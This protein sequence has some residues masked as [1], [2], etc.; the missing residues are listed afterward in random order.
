MNDWSAQQYL[1]FADERTRPAQDLLARV[2]LDG[3]RL[4][5]DIGCGPGNS[6]ELLA[7]RWPEAKV[8]G[9]DSSP[10]ML[11]DARKRL[12]NASFE[13]AD[14]ANWQPPEAPDLLFANAILQWLPD[15][16]LVIQRL[17][18]ALAPGGVI[19]VQMPDNLLEPSHVLMTEAASGLQFA[20]KLSGLARQKLPP[21]GFYQQMLAP[22]ANTVD[23]WHTTYYHPMRDAGAIVE[24]VKGTGLR[25]FLDALAAD[26]RQSYLEAYEAAIA[27]AYPALA[28][29][30]LLLPF[31]RLFM[32]A[33]RG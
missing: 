23:V 26:E 10:A 14:V 6:T 18:A 33:T 24:W 20:E 9:I 1:K 8:Y 25:P 13:L 16:A 19:A 30:T 4:V 32:V 5:V 15:H 12:P 21:A 27:T 22:L 7:G 29:G 28:D 17:F 11:A 31:P 3:P 2:A